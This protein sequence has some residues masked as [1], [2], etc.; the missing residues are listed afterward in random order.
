MKQKWKKL[1]CI[2]ERQ[3]YNSVPLPFH[4]SENIYRIFF[5]TRDQNNHSSPFSIDID[6]VK[7]KILS[8]K[9]IDIDLGDRGAFDENG[10][11]PTSYIQ[12][13]GKIYMYYIGWN[14]GK[15]VP[16][17]NSIGL[18]FSDDEGETFVKYSEGP[19]LDRSMH[20]KCFVA[21]NCV[22]PEDGYYR[23][24]YLSCDRW[25]KT[26]DSQLSPLYNIKYAESKDAIHW[27]RDGHIA[28]DYKYPNEYAISVPRVIFENTI[29]KMWYSYRGCSKAKTYRIGYAESNDGKLWVRKDGKVDLD[30]S[31]NGWDS[32]MICYPYVFDHNGKRYMLYNG[33]D[34]GKTGFG[35]A[36]LEK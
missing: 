14:I 29:Y 25:S 19:I 15:T 31:S 23:M 5:S 4:I 32:D 27:N 22:F 3:Y 21:S 18:M 1:G 36:V 16:F 28:I 7:L 8:E 13:D 12:K 20:D 6:I 34:Y 24:Y 17:R 33:N 11:M 26:A 2:Y 10:I 35:L 9:H 30:V